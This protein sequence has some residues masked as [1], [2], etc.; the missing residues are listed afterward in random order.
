MGTLPDQKW[1]E[2]LEVRRRRLSNAVWVPL[3]Q[4]ETLSSVGKIRKVGFQE[5]VL[6]VGSVAIFKDYRDIGETLEWSDIGLIHN[7]IPYA[8]DDGRYKPAEVYLHWDKDAI[9]V[10]LVLEQSLNGD[11]R[12]RWLVN[13][14][15]VLALGLI[16][17]GD[18]WKCVN[19]GYVDVIRLRRDADGTVVAIEIKAEFLCD[20]LAARGLILRIAQYRQR[21]AILQDA[22]Y[23]DWV[24][25]PKQEIKDHDRFE[26]RVFE[27][28]TDGA[29]FGGSVAVF[30]TWRTDVDNDEDVPV[31]GPETNSNTGSRSSMF[32]RN[33]K[34][35]FSAEGELWREEWIEP[36][37][38]SE[39]VRGDRPSEEIFF[40]VGAAGQRLAS[41]A[42]NSEDIGRYLWFRPSVIEA[43]LC[44]RGSALDWY[45]R[46]TGS[47]KCSPD[48][49]IHFGINRLGLIN[50][51]A[52]DVAKQPYWQQRIWAGHNVAPDGPV[53]A[54]LLDSQMRANPAGT[55]APEAELQ[56]LL[57]EL[58]NIF[59]EQ[60]GSTLFRYH[61]NKE[62]ILARV[63]R[64]R[65]FDQSGLLALAKDLA[66]ITA[67]SID[68]CALRKIVR[69]PAETTW[70]SL[71][72]LENVLAT[73]SDK[74][75][76]RDALT[77]LVGIYEL[78]L[79][80]A[81]MPSS[82]ISDAYHLVGIDVSGSTI[83]Q[84][85]QLLDGAVHSLRTVVSVLSR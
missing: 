85:I 51:Y 28:D 44:Y 5:E 67:D 26:A 56:V 73:K 68:V 63:Y 13:Q 12:R 61:E 58:D 32:E 19:E 41:S 48:H 43:L 31:F 3:R 39:R 53:S 72:H 66:R 81:H 20:Y 70:R 7:P 11:H 2:M 65:A 17:E 22:S 80:D 83:E 54:E 21:M 33:G 4:E 57:I 77:P 29:L 34:K 47:V 25:K 14:D 40:S 82:Q 42:L 55:I 35:A 45:T 37:T 30:E 8:F 27:V 75:T 78:R 15:L 74:K 10:E 46:H 76:A 59:R 71:K 6:C 69:P 49:P 62:Q 18:V 1:F 79:G 64:F 24:S 60:Y 23:L 50:I 9:G 52:Y 16:E 38:F 36:A 84:A